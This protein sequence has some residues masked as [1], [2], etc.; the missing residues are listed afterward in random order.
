MTVRRA[1]AAVAVAL[2]CAAQ[3]PADAPWDAAVP[4]TGEALL[5]RIKAV[6]RAHPRPPFVAY[7]LVRRDT[8]DG[9]P[10]FADSYTLKVW[11][12]THDN[13]A[14]ARR[15]WRGAAHGDLQYLTVMF[16]RA[17]DPG[18][19][20]ADVFERRSFAAMPVTPA[21]HASAP[22]ALPPE[23]LPEIGRV[24][25]R[26]GDYRVLRTVRDGDLLHVWLV[27]RTEPERNRLEELWVDA[28]T[29]DLRRA[30]VRDHLYFAFGA[31]SLEDEFDVRFRPGPGNLPLIA[32]IHGETPGATYETDYT[33]DGV[34]FPDALPDWYFTPKVY[35]LHRADA[36]V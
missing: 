28:T 2:A 10:D 16:D 23:P 4:P 30:L 27:A 29:F 32:S 24:T 3:A 14:L 13:A 36:P 35:G 18:P 33:F 5:A 7:T 8:H 34:T 22:P 15:A 6:Y 11:C 31:T 26:D 20:T 1:L 12:R 19:P 21:A 9:A 17:V 25:S